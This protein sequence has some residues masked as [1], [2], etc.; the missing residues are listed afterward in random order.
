MHDIHV[1]FIGCDYVS[2]VGYRN[3]DIY[4]SKVLL[5]SLLVLF[6]TV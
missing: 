6:T 2:Y 5:F 1:V 4:N 3:G